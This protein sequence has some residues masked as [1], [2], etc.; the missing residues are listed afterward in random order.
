MTEHDKNDD[1][2]QSKATALVLDIDG[3]EGPLD[4]LL[5]LARSQKV[6]LTQISILQLS[7]QYLTFISR[8][9]FLSLEVAA[10]YLVMAAWLAYLKS[11]L[12]IPDFEDEEAPTGPELAA[13]LAFQLKRL[14]AMRKAS[15]KLMLRNRLGRDVFRRGNPEGVRIIRTCLYE[16]SVFEL[17]QSYANHRIEISKES[18][19]ISTREVFSLDEAYDRLHRGLGSAPDWGALESFLPLEI[20]GTPIYR[21]AITAMLGAGLELA[22]SGRA[23]LRQVKAFAPIFIRRATRDIKE[24]EDG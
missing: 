20:K 12:L 22:K 19:D 23:E 1:W 11:R 10:D 7:E 6:D 24:V 16:V 17:L 14:E 18:Y 2:D 4:V 21:S 9:H 5:S 8:V 15:A 13:H 3:Y